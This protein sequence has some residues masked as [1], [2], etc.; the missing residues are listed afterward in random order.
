MIPGI[1][2]YIE[3]APSFQKNGSIVIEGKEEQRKM[4]ERAVN[5]RAAII[6]KSKAG[7]RNG[8]L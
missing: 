7:K 3:H 1:N 6:A 2:V 5:K 8:R 4:R